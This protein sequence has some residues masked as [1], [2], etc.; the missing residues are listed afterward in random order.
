MPQRLSIFSKP[1]SDEKHKG[2]PN[3]PFTYSGM[4]NGAG[5]IFFAAEKILAFRKNW[6]FLFA[7]RIRKLKNFQFLVL[8]CNFF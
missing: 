7:H 8:E 2:D 6:M 1:D 5:K 3:M 4:E